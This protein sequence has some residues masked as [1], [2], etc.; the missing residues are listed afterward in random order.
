LLQKS[1]GS[2]SGGVYA[3]SNNDSGSTGASTY[4]LQLRQQA[5]AAAV[6]ELGSVLGGEQGGVQLSLTVE[7]LLREWQR[8]VV[9]YAKADA[10][11]HICVS[12]YVVSCCT[13]DS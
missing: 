3:G 4:E 13:V 8:D 2:S 1:I 6:G 9:R 11:H 7:E 5:A 10:V 12:K